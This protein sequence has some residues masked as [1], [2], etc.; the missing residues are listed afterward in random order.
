MFGV[1]AHEKKYTC[2]PCAFFDILELIA[3]FADE[4]QKICSYRKR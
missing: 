4:K 3:I 1:K 2:F